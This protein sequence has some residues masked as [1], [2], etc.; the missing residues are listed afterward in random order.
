MQPK[1][2]GD[3]LGG[4]VYDAAQGDPLY[5]VAA[6]SADEDMYGNFV[7]AMSQLD[8][9]LQAHEGGGA[10]S[11]DLVEQAYQLQHT[12]TMRR[13]GGRGSAGGAIPN[14]TYVSMVRPLV[15]SLGPSIKVVPASIAHINVSSPAGAQLRC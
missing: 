7:N 12:G 3:A 8:Q 4:P 15:L 11:D 9:T 13:T 1:G 5:D 2:R 6:A 14:S 10:A